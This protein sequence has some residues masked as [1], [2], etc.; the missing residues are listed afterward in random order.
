VLRFTGASSAI[1]SCH[2][3]NKVYPYTDPAA[4]KDEIFPI[5]LK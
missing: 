1:A 2:C 4:M 5:K 3:P